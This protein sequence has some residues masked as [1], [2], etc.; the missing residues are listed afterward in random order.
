MINLLTRVTFLDSL[1]NVNFL[2]QADTCNYLIT[3]KK[4]NKYN[5]LKVFKMKI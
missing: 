1:T 4:T 2:K 5:N 3:S